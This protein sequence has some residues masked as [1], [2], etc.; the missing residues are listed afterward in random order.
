[1]FASGARIKSEV[2]VDNLFKELDLATK[3]YKESLETE[4]YLKRFE[5]E[6]YFEPENSI[7]IL[8]KKSHEIAI[9]KERLE[10]LEE[11]NDN[12]K[13]KLEETTKLYSEIV[14]KNKILQDNLNY[15]NKHPVKYAVSKI[16]KRK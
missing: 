4:F 10:N 1:M 5:E 7:E 11:K 14:H 12:I 8:R 2:D 9:L 6:K 3:E 13:Q 16:L 15:I